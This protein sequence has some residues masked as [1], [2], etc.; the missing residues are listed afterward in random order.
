M[1]KEIKT[2]TGYSRFTSKNGYTAKLYYTG[3]SYNEYS[4]NR[5]FLVPAESLLLSMS[6][7]MVRTDSVSTDFHLL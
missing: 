3:L 6:D 7:N 2:V 1:E 4:A 5:L